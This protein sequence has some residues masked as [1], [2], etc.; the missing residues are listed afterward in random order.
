MVQGP[1]LTLVIVKF[2]KFSSCVCGFPYESLVF[3]HTSLKHTA[4]CIGLNKLSLDVCVMARDG[5]HTA[6][7]G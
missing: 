7:A 5:P 2:C 6:F 3:S 4:V 1:I